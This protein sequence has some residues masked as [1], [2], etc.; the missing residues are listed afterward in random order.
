MIPFGMTGILLWV[1]VRNKVDRQLLSIL[2]GLLW[3]TA[4]VMP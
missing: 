1:L 2:F 3:L 4:V